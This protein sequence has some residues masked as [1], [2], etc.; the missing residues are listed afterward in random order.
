MDRFI[1]LV[2]KAKADRDKL[3]RRA[4]SIAES[5][6]VR[7]I[8]IRVASKH[9]EYDL[10][11]DNRER[12]ELFASKIGDPMEIRGLDEKCRDSILQAREL[13]NSERFWE[14]HELLE[15][16][17]S[18]TSGREKKLLNGLILVAAAFVHLQRGDRDSFFR[19]LERSL[20]KL[21]KTE[22][23][24]VGI[25]IKDVRKNVEEILRDGKPRIFK[26]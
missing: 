10:F 14:F 3:L 12:A 5:M 1:I 15:E 17:W 20:G 6:G 24:I 7:L 23:N 21:G 19:V 18:K 26:I 2:K 4:K 11:A 8:D 13:F 16:L 9:I 25:P 22:E